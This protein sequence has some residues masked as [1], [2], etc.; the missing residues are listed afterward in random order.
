MTNE[1]KEEE[2]EED[3][4]EE[5]EEEVGGEEER[6]EGMRGLAGLLHAF[7]FCCVLCVLGAFWN[8]AFS[9]HK[10]GFSAY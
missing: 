3:E 9:E 6:E 10:I 7:W 5:E 1:D 4:E 8:T 2:D